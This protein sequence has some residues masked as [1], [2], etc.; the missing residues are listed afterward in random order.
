M[1]ELKELLDQNNLEELKKR[2]HEMEKDLSCESSLAEQQRLKAL[3]Y[4]LKN[5]Y[6]I[7]LESNIRVLNEKKQFE[8]EFYN[9]FTGNEQK[10]YLKG[11][12]N[13]S[14]VAFKCEEL[15]LETSRFVRTEDIIIRDTFLLK[16]IFDSN[17]YCHTTNLRLINCHRVTIHAYTLNGVFLQDCTGITIDPLKEPGNMC[18]KVYD[19][20]SPV[21]KKN[22]CFVSDHEDAE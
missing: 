11:L 19:F 20:S 9:S 17:I 4:E 16:D 21:S 15:T 6:F 7:K 1:N 10:R 8:P 5:A 2:I 22:Y 18:G 13:T 12:H 3:I 14:V